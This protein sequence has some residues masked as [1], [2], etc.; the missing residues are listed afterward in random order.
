MLTAG[1]FDCV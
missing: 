1:Q